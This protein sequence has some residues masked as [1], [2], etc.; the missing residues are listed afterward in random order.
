MTY[1]YSTLQTTDYRQYT[2]TVDR[3][4]SKTHFLFGHVQGSC[5]ILL[6]IILSTLELKHIEQ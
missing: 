3:E 6:I 2:E 4:L 5:D 1:A